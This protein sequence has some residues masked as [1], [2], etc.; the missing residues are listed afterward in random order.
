MTS[1]PAGLA[2]LARRTCCYIGAGHR[3]VGPFPAAPVAVRLAPW[4]SPGAASGRPPVNPLLIARQPSRVNLAEG[5]RGWSLC[6][7]IDVVHHNDHGTAGA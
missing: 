1:W 2:R 7:A 3:A 5:N 4:P 6:R